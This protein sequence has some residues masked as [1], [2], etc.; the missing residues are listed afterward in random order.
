MPP[1]IHIF[2]IL[3]VAGL[4]LFGAEIFVPGGILGVVGAIALFAAIIIG[5]SQFGFTTGSLIAMGIIALMG[6]AMVLWIKIF[7]R[8]GLGKRMIVSTN[9]ASA[10]AS[11]TGI[12]DLI[13]KSGESSSDL[14]PGGFATIDGKRIDVITQGEMI[15][16][17]E[18]I[19]VIAIDGNRIVV[20]K[21]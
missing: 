15:Q 16:R 13:G 2:F 9:L 17:G 20:S 4:F 14:R 12:K 7:P 1:I 10:K 6:L 8:T 18:K 19:K 3:L 21:A 11:Q 5:Y